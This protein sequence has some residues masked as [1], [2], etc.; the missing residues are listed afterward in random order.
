MTGLQCWSSP[1]C[2][3][4]PPPTCSPRATST[5]R[6]CWTVGATAGPASPWGQTQVCWLR[7]TRPGPERSGA[8]ASVTHP[9]R[10]SCPIWAIRG[11]SRLTSP[12]GN[13]LLRCFYVI[14]LL[15]FSQN[16]PF[17]PD[18]CQWQRRKDDLPEVSFSSNEKHLLANEKSANKTV[19]FI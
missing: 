9:T 10:C 17:S 1:P 15:S 4:P 7:S 18:E 16:K 19:T 5:W 3:T 6:T 8:P 14:R 11:C 12:G 2:L 13:H